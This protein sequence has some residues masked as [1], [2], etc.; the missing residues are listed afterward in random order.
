[1]PRRGAGPAQLSHSRRLA[2]T[3][4]APH[5]AYPPRLICLNAAWPTKVGRRTVE[6]N[7]FRLGAAA[8]S[9]HA[10]PAPLLPPGL[11]RVWARGRGAPL[12]GNHA[13]AGAV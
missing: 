13:G 8:V 2:A 10:V 6:R 4:A 9:A 1:M 7:R 3:S 12:G 5:V 11:L